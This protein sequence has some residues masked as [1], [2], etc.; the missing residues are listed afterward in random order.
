MAVSPSEFAYFEEIQL[1]DADFNAGDDDGTTLSSSS[2]QIGEI[3][4]MEV[5]EDGV[6]SSYAIAAMGGRKSGPNDTNPA[7]YV[8]LQNSTPA[9]LD[10]NTQYRFVS[11]DKNSNR[12]RTLTDWKTLRE[13]DNSDPRQRPEIVYRGRGNERWVQDGKLIILEVRNQSTDVAPSLSDSTIEVKA[14]AGSR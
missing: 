9:A 11:R 6:L 13:S 3:A 4:E 10:D 8:D 2:G 12:K 1:T 14:V 7:I 5:G